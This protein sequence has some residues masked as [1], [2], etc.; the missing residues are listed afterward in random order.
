MPSATTT[1]V[2]GAE[3]RSVRLPAVTTISKEHDSGRG[4]RRRNNQS[5]ETTAVRTSRLPRCGLK[6]PGCAKVTLW[7]ARGGGHSA[8]AAGGAVARGLSDGEAAG[9]ALGTVGGAALAELPHHANFAPVHAS[10]VC[11]LPRRATATLVGSQL[12]SIR[13]LVKWCGAVVVVMG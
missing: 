3:S 10:F 6:P 4:E 2:A 5:I 8:G 13:A 9:R 7:V 12:G 1:S 11:V